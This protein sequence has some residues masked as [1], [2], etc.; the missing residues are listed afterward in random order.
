M[1]DGETASDI[2]PRERAD[3][4]GRLL[5]GG[6]LALAVGM[7]IGRFFYT[8]L[9]PL[10]QRDVGFGSGV[11]GLIASVNFVGYLLGTVIGALIPKGRTRVLVFRGSLIASI[12]TTLATGL[13]DSVPLWL[14]LRGLA[15][16]ASAFVFLFAANIVA[17]ALT[18]AA[19]PARIG[20]LFGGVGIGIALSGLIARLASGFLDWRGLWIAAGVLGA[21]LAPFI[22]M[23]V[24]DTE[25]RPNLRVRAIPRHVPHPLP[26]WPLLVNYTCEGF[27]YSI[28]ATFI[29]AIV[30]ARPGMESIGDWV[31]VVVGLAGLPSCIF[32]FWIGERIGFSAALA[33]AYVTQ[34][35]GILLPALT[36]TASAA[37][38]SALFFGGT[39]MAIT[40][41]ILALGRQ[42]AQGRGFAVLTAG[43]GLGQIM[44]PLAAGYLV[45]GKT[46]FNEALFVS[47]GTILIGLVF[48]ALAE[49]Q[50]RAG[51]RISGR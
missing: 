45:V 4:A 37:L 48:L 19:Q 2:D 7:G 10:M 17:E 43:F 50:A 25:L 42:S 36:E 23:V 11:A 41:L 8:P 40:A 3:K 13:T 15:G 30:K 32:W 21:V 33:L 27:G 28:V 34:F 12:A 14:V 46:N 1:S 47:A 31:W 29:V 35:V 38:L 24:K 9:L 5:L 51:E 22:L 39:F 6:F 16:V 20:W 44:G 49:M 26:L 18:K